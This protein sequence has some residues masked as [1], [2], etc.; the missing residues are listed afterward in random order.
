VFY[1]PGR[2]LFIHVPRTGGTS[3]SAALERAYPGWVRDFSQEW[4]HATAARLRASMPA[5]DW[6]PLYKFAVIRDPHECI[7]SAWRY[8]RQESAKPLGHLE[9]DHPLWVSALRRVGGYRSFG[10]Y[11][12]AEWFDR[13]TCLHTGGFLRTWCHGPAGVRVFRHERLGEAWASVCR[14]LGIPAVELPHANG[15]A[16]ESLDWPPGLW[17][18]VAVRCRGDYSDLLPSR[19]E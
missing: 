4:K 1:V 14:D 19:R 13:P 11:V 2:V 3:I 8:A 7:E 10:D 16:S 5:E 6:G 9:R 18:E 12:Q 15:A 17:R